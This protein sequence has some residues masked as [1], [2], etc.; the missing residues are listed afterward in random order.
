[1]SAGPGDAP[2]RAFDLIAEIARL[3]YEV[4]PDGKTLT[5]KTTGMVEQNLVF[6]RK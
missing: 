5:A 6:E 2:P 1:M 3:I 4:W